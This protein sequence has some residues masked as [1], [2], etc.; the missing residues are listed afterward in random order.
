MEK[1][2]KAN[3]LLLAEKSYQAMLE[4]ID[5]LKEHD[6]PHIRHN[7]GLCYEIS[8]QYTKAIQQY[9]TNVEKNPKYIRSYI[10]LANCYKNQHDLDTSLEWLEKA[11]ALDDVYPQTYF[12]LSAHYRVLNDLKKS[13]HF[14]IMGYVRSAQLEAQ[15]TIHYTRA[16]M[17]PMSTTVYTIRKGAATVLDFLYVENIP[18]PDIFMLH[19]FFDQNVGGSNSLIFKGKGQCAVKLKIG[20]VSEFFVYSG[21]LTTILPILSNHDRDNYEIYTYSLAEF[22]DSY[23]DIVRSHSQFYRNDDK[24]GMAKKIL[25][26]K[27]DILI[28]LDGHTGTQATMNTLYNRLA[29]V[30][31]DFLGYPFSTGKKSIDYKI[32]DAFTD[33]EDARVFYTEKLL[34]PNPCFLVWKPLEE[35]PLPS[36]EGNT[37]HTRLLSPNNFKKLSETTVEMYSDILKA[38]DDVHIYFKSSFHASGDDISDFFDLHFGQFKERVHFI[39]FISDKLEHYALTSTFDIALDTYPYSGTLTTLECLYCS[40][41]VVTLMGSH[42]RSRVS[43]DILNVTGHSELVANHPGEYVD[44]VLKLS[45]NTKRIAKY[46]ETLRNDLEKSPI[47][48]Y[49]KY[50]KNLENAMRLL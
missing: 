13:T 15:D 31:V 50:V 6:Y 8:Q 33:G 44:I 16:Y 37:G 36:F 23:T 40:V 1:L 34:R 42:H 32:V 49:S 19:Q 27:L 5:V 46:H 22:E 41:P 35:F 18:E 26:D 38:T 29:R 17:D 3:D 2:S 12:L 24:E 25:E 48:N 4:Y 9:K 11:L 39:D 45:G 43:A 10:G 7:I 47:M 28:S 21:I 20:Y 14:C 30:Q